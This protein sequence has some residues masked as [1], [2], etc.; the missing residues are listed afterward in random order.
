MKKLRQW[1]PSRFGHTATRNAIGRF[2]HAAKLS[3]KKVK[4]LLGKANPQKRVEHIARLEAIFERVCRG[5]VIL[6]GWHGLVFV[7]MR[8]G[9]APPF[10]PRPDMATKTRPCHPA[11]PA[12]QRP[13]GR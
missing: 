9:C 5:E 13:N 6:A 12:I 11:I 7:A 10:A 8:S 2:L 3:W 4:K 1:A